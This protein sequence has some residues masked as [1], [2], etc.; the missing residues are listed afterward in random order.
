MLFGDLDLGCGQGVLLPETHMA[1]PIYA[2]GGQSCGTARNKKDRALP[3]NG[4][5]N[6]D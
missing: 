4:I 6:L 3:Q 2:R 1:L 5:W